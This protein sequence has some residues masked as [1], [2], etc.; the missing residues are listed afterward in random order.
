MRHPI[1][2]IRQM[3]V[4]LAPFE[5]VDDKTQSDR[6]GFAVLAKGFEQPFDRRDSHAL[7]VVVGFDVVFGVQQLKKWTP[8]FGQPYK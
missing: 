8:I 1:C 4:D 7:L 5:G 2:G 3:P 6:D